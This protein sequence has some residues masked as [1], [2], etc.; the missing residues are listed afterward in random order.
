MNL[1]P[2]EYEDYV[3]ALVDYLRSIDDGRMVGYKIGEYP[4]GWFIIPMYSDEFAT[5][6]EAYT[7]YANSTHTFILS[8]TSNLNVYDEYGYFDGSVVFHLEYAEKS[9]S[10]SISGFSY[11]LV[12][13]ISSYNSGRY[14]PCYYGHSMRDYYFPVAGTD[15]SVQYRECTVCTHKEYETS[16]N[17]QKYSVTYAAGKDYVKM[18]KTYHY[19]GDIV[20]LET[21]IPY[22]AD[23]RVTVNG[24]VIPKFSVSEYGFT[25]V[26]VTPNKD[27][28]ISIELIDSDMEHPY[29]SKLNRYE[30]WLL[31][32]NAEDIAKIQITNEN[33]SLPQGSFRYYQSVTDER[34]VRSFCRSLADMGM[35]RMAENFVPANTNFKVIEIILKD[36]SSYKI[37]LYD[38]CYR[39]GDVYYLFN[40]KPSLLGYKDVDTSIC[41]L[42]AGNNAVKLYSAQTDEYI[43]ELLGLSSL[44]FRECDEDYSNAAPT[45]YIETEFGRINVYSATVF[46]LLIPPHLIWVTSNS[47]LPLLFSM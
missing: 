27:I 14:Y 21:Y 13:R 15:L 12:M 3:K 8:K 10:N 6:T 32:V 43:C 28:E 19:A 2:K 20:Y 35:K 42:V 5:L 1:T 26:F 7:D 40:T 37:E 11:N 23:L 46:E 18:P 38:E 25:Y 24:T 34:S 17:F 9:P 31:D 39:I 41:S 16:G 45:H 29:F 47:L 36:G 44:E 33:P 30:E 22:D 4:S